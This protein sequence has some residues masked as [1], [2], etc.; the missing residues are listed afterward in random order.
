VVTELTL[1]VVSLVFSQLTAV[2]FMAMRFARSE[3]RVRRLEEG[4][5]DL[6]QRLRPHAPARVADAEDDAPRYE[7][8]SYREAHEVAARYPLR[9]P[10]SGKD[11]R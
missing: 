3:E 9:V 1:V 10:G 2:V 4:V 11:R 6:R 7:D 8:V 5:A